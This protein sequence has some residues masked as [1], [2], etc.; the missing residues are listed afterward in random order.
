[1]ARRVSG[2]PTMAVEL[3]TRKLVQRAS[4]RPPPKAVLLIA[5]IVGTGRVERRVKTE[6]REVRKDRVLRKEKMLVKAL[7]VNSVMFLPCVPRSNVNSKTQSSPS[8]PQ[9]LIHLQCLSNPSTPQ[10]KP[11]N[12]ANQ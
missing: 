12:T 9:H 6:R 1:M 10:S 11:K 7:D 4:S 3:K 2:S 8:T 5:L